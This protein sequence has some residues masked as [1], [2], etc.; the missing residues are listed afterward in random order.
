MRIALAFL[1]C[2]LAL[3]AAFFTLAIWRIHGPGHE[4]ERASWGRWRNLGR[5]EQVGSG[6]F[7]LSTWPL[8]AV[9][10]LVLDLTDT[11]ECLLRLVHDLRHRP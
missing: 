6:L 1:L 10:R 5:Q 11:L 3:G 8:F 7:A 9:A 2:Y 4:E